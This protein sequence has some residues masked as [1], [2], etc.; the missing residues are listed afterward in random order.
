M[1]IFRTLP[2]TAS[3]SVNLAATASSGGGANGV[4]NLAA[5]TNGDRWVLENVIVSY[6]TTSTGGLNVYNGTSSGTLMFAADIWN[7][8]ITQ[9]DLNLTAG[10]NN[11][12]AV[13]LLQAGS[14]IIGKLNAFARRL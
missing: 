2:L 11:A 10:P 5:P 3:S 1:R 7:E 14:S 13:E 6:T 4:V 12:M 8:G 9:I